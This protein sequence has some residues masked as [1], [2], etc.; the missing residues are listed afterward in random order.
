M[1]EILH[2][3]DQLEEAHP[4][5]VFRFRASPNIKGWQ[6]AEGWSRS[7]CEEDYCFFEARWAVEA[8]EGLLERLEQK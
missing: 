2:L 6:I 1:I 3:L 8:L 5:M 4:D 7:N